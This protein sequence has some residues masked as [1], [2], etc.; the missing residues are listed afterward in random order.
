VP[1]PAI[2]GLPPGEVTILSQN[3][4]GAAFGVGTG[5]GLLGVIKLQTAGKKT[6]SA[7]DFLRGQRDF[8]G[9]VLG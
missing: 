4:M 9:G 7:A 8:A 5:T 1:L 6:M 3:I 2:E